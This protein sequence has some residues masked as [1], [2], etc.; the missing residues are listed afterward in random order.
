MRKANPALYDL[1]NPVVEDMGYE[2]LGI[3][4]LAQ[5]RH[6]TLRLFIDKPGGITLDDCE[7]VSRQ[8]SSLM[9]VED[10]IK[11]NYSLEVSS[12]GL[13]RPLF[14][15]EHFARFQGQMAQIRLIAPFE[16]RRKFQGII[17][18]VNGDELTLQIGDEDFHFHMD[19]IDKAELVPQF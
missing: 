11:G 15:P 19:D 1:L 7:K 13:D 16:G 14:T 4:H 8:V 5:G 3:E 18:A 2:L 6:S 9:D 10:P 12:P 17:V